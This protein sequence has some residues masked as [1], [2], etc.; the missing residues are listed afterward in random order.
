MR[1]EPPWSPPSVMLDVVVEQ[2]GGGTS[3]RAARQ[4]SGAVWI[5]RWAVGAGVARAG[6]GEVVHVKRRR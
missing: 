5:Q 2:R 4:V 6:K 1:M 3:R